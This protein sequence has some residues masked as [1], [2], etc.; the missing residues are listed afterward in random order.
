M[1][2]SE[3]ASLL[4]KLIDEFSREPPAGRDMRRGTATKSPAAADK[5]GP[6]ADTSPQTPAKAAGP[7]PTMWR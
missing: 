6:S 3:I 4:R 2:D 7:V 1:V 5:D